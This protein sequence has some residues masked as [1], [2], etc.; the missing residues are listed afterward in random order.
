[1][2]PGSGGVQPALQVVDRS[3]KLAAP[4]KAGRDFTHVTPA[5]ERRHFENV[6]QRE[7]RAAVLGVFFEQRL[8]YLARPQK[9]LDLTAINVEL[10][11][12]DVWSLMR[13]RETGEVF[14]QLLVSKIGLRYLT[15]LKHLAFG[16]K[17]AS[18]SPTG[19]PS[20]AGSAN[21]SVAVP[22]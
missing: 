17:A 14:R 21:F 12:L 20:K 13:L 22:V 8:Q 9:N 18:C 11:R 15:L 3:P 10:A 5:A 4:A 7:L 19:S 6:G 16:V 2:S 1:M